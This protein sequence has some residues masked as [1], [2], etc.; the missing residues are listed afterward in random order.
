VVDL[1]RGQP[2]VTPIEE[3]SR[4]PPCGS[5]ESPISPIEVVRI[6]KRP[7]ARK[8]GRQAQSDRV[9]APQQPPVPARS[10]VPTEHVAWL[11]PV[12]TL[13]P[14]PTD[15]PPPAPA[16]VTGWGT[17]LAA[18]TVLCCGALVLLLGC[19]A[20]AL[21]FPPRSTQPDHRPITNSIG[22]KLVFIPAGKFTMGSPNDEANRSADEQQH[23][24]AITREF[25]L[26]VYEVTQEE[27]E[28]VMGQN[29]SW[30][31][32]GGDGKERVA[33]LDTR[34]FPV[35]NVSWEDAVEFCRKLSARAAETKAGRAYRLPTEAEWEYACRGGARSSEPFHFGAALS[36]TQANFD[37]NLPYGG[38]AK[39]PYMGRTCRVGSYQP[40]GFGLYDLHGELAMTAWFPALMA[41]LGQPMATNNFFRPQCPSCSHLERCAMLLCRAVP[42]RRKQGLQLPR[43]LLSC[44]EGPAPQATCCHLSDRTH[45]NAQ[46]PQKF[47]VPRDE[48][49]AQGVSG[50]G[51]GRTP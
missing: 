28:T 49:Q 26:G 8:A 36:S 15:T 46:E 17:S 21:V 9:D 13:A 22:M 45:R 30:F 29:P 20:V 33:G 34:R 19:L 14:A 16:R 18:A 50:N 25:Y 39:G 42:A 24:V 38:A 23:E 48:R 5:E 10:T 1:D 7:R 3:S 51:R 35:E 32:A 40:N 37:G 31:C 44:G 27:Y 12:A 4:T 11:V 41:K 2:L 47:L 43:H 6:Q